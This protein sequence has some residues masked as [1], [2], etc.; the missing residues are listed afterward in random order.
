MTAL[1]K[2][3]SYYLK[4]HPG[5]THGPWRESSAS[6]RSTHGP[7]G[8][9]VG[10][11]RQ[12]KGT[13]TAPTRP[14]WAPY[15]PTRPSHCPVSARIKVLGAV[16][17]TDSPAPSAAC[18][19]SLFGRAYAPSLPAEPAAPLPGGTASWDHEVKDYNKKHEGRRAEAR[20]PWPQARAAKPMCPKSRPITLTPSPR[21]FFKTRRRPGSEVVKQA[22]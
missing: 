6:Q 15:I 9:P 4:A 2:K 21:A 22:M 18:R 3:E 16:P 17:W 19:R 20:R 5:P 1:S 11:P 12:Y 7:P 10:P 13:H 14:S 8:Y